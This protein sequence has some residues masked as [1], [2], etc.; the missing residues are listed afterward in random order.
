VL[1]YLSILRNYFKNFFRL[2]KDKSASGGELF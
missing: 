1:L 2:L